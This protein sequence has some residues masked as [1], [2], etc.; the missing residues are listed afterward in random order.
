M[1]SVCHAD[2]GDFEVKIVHELDMFSSEQFCQALTHCAEADDGEAKIL[3]FSYIQDN[4]R[5]SSKRL[6]GPKFKVSMPMPSRRAARKYVRAPTTI[7]IR[8]FMRAST[9]PLTP[10]NW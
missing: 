9:V 5:R 10:S 2:K 8:S 4:F 6:T 3:H 7:S 1:A